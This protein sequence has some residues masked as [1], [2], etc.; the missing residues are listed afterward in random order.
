MRSLEQPT[1]LNTSLRATSF[2]LT[3]LCLLV[4]GFLVTPSFVRL[5]NAEY[6]SAVKEYGDDIKKLT[7][8]LQDRAQ[9]FD[10]QEIALLEFKSRLKAL[11]ERERERTQAGSAIDQDQIAK[12]NFEIESM[13]RTR[14]QTSN[15]IKSLEQRRKELQS[16]VDKAANESTNLYLVARALALG[17][18][19]AFMS[20]LAKSHQVEAA[21]KDDENRL[22]RVWGSMAIGGIVAVV[23]LG[24]F[25]TK[26]I[27]IFS[28]SD[29]TSSAPD[30]WRVTILCLMA[31]AFADRIF[32]AAAGR[33]DTYLGDKASRQLQT[34][35]RKANTVARKTEPI[36]P[37]KPQ[38]VADEK[39]A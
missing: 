5:L 21:S 18:L 3:L 30:F 37:P 32:A 19:G 31:G 20:L 39:Q 33:V 8:I 6:W 16:I 28:H 17:A 26:Q 10:K 4:I 9:D 27:S 1:K 34:L 22:Q 36:K 38:L 15:E 13:Q 7:L 29:Q 14:D 2:V 23:V 11:L 12:Y 24:L 35:K 25:Y